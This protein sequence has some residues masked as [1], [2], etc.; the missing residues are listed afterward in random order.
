MQQIE[1]QLERLRFIWKHAPA[2]E[3]H[4]INVT[5]KALKNGLDPE[6]VKRRI[7]AHER[8]FSKNKYDV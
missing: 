6:T 5:G 4:A 3:R 1:P 2:E 8:R 7:A